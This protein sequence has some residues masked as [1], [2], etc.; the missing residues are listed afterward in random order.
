MAYVYFGITALIFG[1]NFKLMHEA[2]QVYQPSFVALVRLGGAAAVLL[3]AWWW[4]RSAWRM[5][6]RDV[7]WIAVVGLLGN[8]WPFLLIPILLQQ[9]V[10]HS[11]VAMFVPFTPLLTI[12]VS[13]PLLGIR[14]TLRQVVGVGGG[15]ALLLVITTDGDKH[16]ASVWFV[17]LALTVPLGYACANTLIRR[18]LSQAP[19]LPLSAALTTTS[20]LAIMPYAVWQCREGVWA[21]SAEVST[22]QIAQAT[23]AVLVLGLVGTGMA[24]GMFVSLIQRKGPLFAG[25]VTYLVPPI[26]LLWGWLDEEAITAVQL[27][28]I[29]GILAMV[30][31]V[32]YNPSSNTQTAD[33]RGQKSTALHSEEALDACAAGSER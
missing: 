15:L 3:A 1:S 25:M 28:A 26:A 22:V 14:P 16:G 5:T 8:A 30:A 33:G 12:V 23:V 2:T 27:G 6:H 32:Q 17:L 29:V 9:G 4:N 18:V 20:T 31:L 11:F 24:V 13:L 7:K 19:A 21:T 10:E